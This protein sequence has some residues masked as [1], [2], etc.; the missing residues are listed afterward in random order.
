MSTMASMLAFAKSAVSNPD[1]SSR[2]SNYLISRNVTIHGR[3]TSVR[4]EPDMWVALRDICKRERA[5][6]HEVCSAVASYRREG[7]S[8]TAA[9]RV[10]IMVYFRAA[11]TDE[12]HQRAGHGHGVPSSILSSILTP[13][14]LSNRA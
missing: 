10:F 5:S 6:L 8:L 9:I 3:R 13:Q 7:T 11:A 2:D 14:L 12:G 4:L 1:E